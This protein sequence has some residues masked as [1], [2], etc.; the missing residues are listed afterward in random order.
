MRVAGMARGMGEMAV[1]VV[2]AA[3]LLL[4]LP[5]RGV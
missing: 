3:G 2:D 1:D 5:R 4:L